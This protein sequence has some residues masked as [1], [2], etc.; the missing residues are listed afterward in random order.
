MHPAI[1]W[2]ISMVTVDKHYRIRRTYY[3]AELS[4]PALFGRRRVTHEPPERVILVSARPEVLKSDVG[5]HSKRPLIDFFRTKV[6]HALKGDVIRW[7]GKYAEPRPLKLQT[8][9][10]R[11]LTHRFSPNFF[12]INGPQFPVDERGKSKFGV[13]I[14][15]QGRKKC[16][17]GFG[18]LTPNSHP[19]A[20]YGLGRFVAVGK[21]HRT[22]KTARESVKQFRRYGDTNFYRFWPPN[23][24]TGNGRGQMTSSTGRARRDLRLTQVWYA[25]GARRRR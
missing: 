5:R 19:L 4:I 2:L 6:G 14:N 16:N 12:S 10:S 24:E 1:Y 11:I 15:F 13:L 23:G 17:L 18:A 22:A 20:I 3:A 9:F 8:Q 25:Y 21:R 7:R